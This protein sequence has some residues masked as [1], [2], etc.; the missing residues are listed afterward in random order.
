MKLLRIISPQ[1]S[2]ILLPFLGFLLFAQ[3]SFSQSSIRR[4]LSP[5]YSTEYCSRESHAHAHEKEY[6]NSRS[7]IPTT[8]TS[9]NS[10][11]FKNS[12]NYSTGKEWASL[13]RSGLINA[14]R[15]NSDYGCY[16]DMFVFSSSYSR[17]LFSNSKVTAVAKEVGKLASSY[18]GT[19][20]TGIYGLTIY[21]HAAIFLDSNQLGIDKLTDDTYNEIREA[22]GRLAR[23]SR[24]LQVNEY[25]L[26]VLEELLITSGIIEIRYDP[27]VINGFEKVIK[28]FVVTKSWKNITDITLLKRYV[29][30]VNNV[31]NAVFNIIDAPFEEALVKDGQIIDL[32]GEAAIN[33]DLI[34]AGEDLKFLWQNAAGALATLAESKKL[35]GTVQGHLAT[36]TNTFPK[37][38]PSWVKAK[39]ALNKYGDCSAYNLCQNPLS[40]KEEVN[41]Y[42][43]QKTINYDDGEMIIKTSLSDEKIQNL[44]HA[45]KQVQSQFF[46]LIQTDE[47]VTGDT[48]DTINMIIFSSQKEYQDYASLLFGIPTDNG[49]IYIESIATFYTWDRV[50]GQESRFSLE[51][52]VRHEYTHYLQ[53]RYLVP[54][55]WN[56]SDIY[57]NDRLVWY[58]EGMAEFLT[59]STDTDGVRML[60]HNAREIKGKGSG[61]PTLSTVFRSSYASG[62]NYHYTYGNAAWY[63]WYLNNFDYLKRFFDYTRNND[64]K[65]FDNLVNHLRS[66]GQDSYNDFLRSVSNDEIATWE[67]MTNWSDDNLLNIG[68][69]SGIRNEMGNLPNTSSVTVEMDA[70]TSYRRFKIKGKIRG[71]VRTNTN[72][73]GAKEI[74]K[75]LK[76]IILKLRDNKLVNNFDYTVGYFKNLNISGNTPIADFIITGPLK[77]ADISEDPV[78]DFSSITKSVTAGSKVKFKNE[79][80][81]YIKGLNWSFPSGSPSSVTD[82]QSPEI[83][84]ST[85]G[86]YSVTLTATGQSGANTKTIQK[87]IKVYPAS[88]NTYCAAL[89][90][91]GD[92]VH[93]TKVK[94][95]DF[96]QVSGYTASSYQDNTSLTTL[97]RANQNIPLSIELHNEHW[98]FNALGVWIDWNQDGD[99]EDSGEEIYR[100]YGPG[101][102]SKQITPPTG[103]KLGTTRMRVRLS[104]GAEKNIV[105]CGTQSSIGE[106]EDYSIIVTNEQAPVNIA[107]EITILKPSNGQK[108]VQKDNIAVETIIKDDGEIEKVELK[109]DGKLFSTDFVAPYQWTHINK[110]NFLD[111][112]EHE[113]TITAY[114]NKGK[115]SSSKVLINIEKAPII[116]CDAS[117]KDGSL[118]ITK[119][120]FGSINNETGHSP[121]SDHTNITTLVQKNE[122]VALAINTINEHWSYNA[123]GA[124][125]DWNQD[126]DFID[127][128]EEIY[129]LY[130]PGPFK[131]TVSIPS[132]APTGT[133]LRMRVRLGYGSPERIN[134]CG[135]DNRGEVEDYIVYVGTISGPTCD[136][137][138]QNGDETGVDCGGSCK[139]CTVDPTCDDG[140]QNGDETGVDCGGSCEPCQT[141]VTYCDMKGNNTADDSIVNVNFA[142]INNASSNSAEGYENYTAISGNVTKEES[143]NLKVTIVGYQGG[144]NNEVYAWFD[145]NIDGD[146]T[147]EGEKFNITTKT[148]NT[149]RELSINIPATA[150]I[151]STRMRIVVGYNANDGNS[152]CGTISYG[153]VEDYTINIRSNSEPS[154]NDGIQN[155]NETGI[156]CG[157]SCNPCQVPITYCSATGNT[158]PEGI[159]NVSFASINKSSTRNESGYDDFTSLSANV[160]AGS[161][162]DLKVTI[163]GY[164]GGENDEVYAWFDWN[165]DGDF[166]DEGESLTLTKETGLTGN[167]SVLIPETA[168]N[169]ITRM[170][171]LVSYYNKENNPCDTGTN[172]VRFGEY[173]DYTIVVSGG[174]SKSVDK[175]TVIKAYPNPFT[176]TVTIDV[177][178]LKSDSIGVSVYDITGKQVI[179]KNYTKNPGL[180]HLE[181]VANLES[182]SYFVRVQT[183]GQTE[184]LR[185]VGGSAK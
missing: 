33:T 47:P 53:G 86:E 59:G 17:T 68:T 156:D 182:G 23:N 115:S 92:R 132:F 154:C 42:L 83:T 146:F 58:E 85:A 35:I 28:D 74:D 122:Q 96:E 159:T 114:D 144:A 158:G 168:T 130:G 138:I 39:L 70:E 54:G 27:D 41:D 177:S 73:K 176:D 174:K 185:I 123:V 142:G 79:S 167:V 120:V 143:E 80:R 46:K 139:P 140:I 178:L 43:F 81:G 87:F 88:S 30:S 99:F 67:P 94:L 157:G 38:S 51:S 164:S 105:P 18:N 3:S 160:S 2:K 124:W 172:D 103:V 149:I 10:V 121:Y 129:S 60:A 181:E 127:E 19:N 111:P 69:I 64:I 131:A 147:D 48:N 89:N 153:E 50:V 184:I 110:L 150:K 62:N 145:W 6:T 171:V 24:I 26:G 112:G 72:E 173:E 49:G 1:E 77:D 32:L 37:L 66:N 57:K 52:L 179:R 61:W 133:P 136:D 84:Y 20:S 141:D 107:P 36:I 102:Y 25:A 95:G 162:Y 106:I 11:A 108:F 55:D 152:S 34:D 126:G 13:S 165:I 134:P 116:Y 21:L 135:V 91:G 31:Y 118:H 14:M 7:Y 9:T 163:E 169:G 78:A 98:N 16:G 15:Q 93:I 29:R 117:S 44:Y 71:T 161:R 82:E 137:G 148:S 97:V 101:P 109:V 76:A 100:K 125:I 155:G 65:G 90:E 45:I 104:Y 56:G 4:P 166:T 128:K 22:C 75:Q 113:L 8:R 180:V 40:I 5:E 175:E 170:R 151:G 183:V 119:V 63:N 12:C